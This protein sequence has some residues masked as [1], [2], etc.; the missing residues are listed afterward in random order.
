MTIGGEAFVYRLI[1]GETGGTA[2]QRTTTAQIVIEDDAYV[3]NL[4]AAGD[5]GSMAE[6]QIRIKGG[7]VETLTGSR[8]S[9]GAVKD[10]TVIL[11]DKGKLPTTVSISNATMI[12]G[13]KKLV[14]SGLTLT[15]DPGTKWDELEAADQSVLTLTGTWPAV[16]KT[17]TGGK[18]LLPAPI[19]SV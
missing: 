18:I 15:L 7:N 17:S 14:Y 19:G 2:Q 10:L 4:Y 11:S 3:K 13:T 8:K 9:D 6:T 1:A 5:K 12:T 16:L